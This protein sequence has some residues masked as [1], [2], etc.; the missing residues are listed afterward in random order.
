[1]TRAGHPERPAP[2]PTWS[3]PPRRPRPRRSARRPGPG[4]LTPTPP[5]AP[6]PH[7]GGPAAH[8]AAPGPGPAGAAAAPRAARRHSAARRRQF[9]VVDAAAQCHSGRGPR[10]GDP[11][12]TSVRIGGGRA[13]LTTSRSGLRPTPALDLLPQLERLAALACPR[14]ASRRRAPCAR[15]RGRSRP[16]RPPCGRTVPGDDLR[17]HQR[18]RSSDTPCPVA[19][20]SSTTVSI[21]PAGR[22]LD[23]AQEPVAHTRD[24][25]LA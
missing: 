4:A 21:A 8:Q 17:H 23:A 5:P 13:P 11:G 18:R 15:C 1:M 10:V 3:S 9:A 16:A 14:P 22:R 19:G 2:P 12:A 7:R 6:A 25:Q 24:G 20:A